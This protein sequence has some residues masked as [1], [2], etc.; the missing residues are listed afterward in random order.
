MDPVQRIEALYQAGKITAEEAQMLRE[1]VEG[2]PEAAQP[3]ASPSA[4]VQPDPPVAP[5]A[6]EAAQVPV[7]LLRLE[8]KAGDVTVEGDPQLTELQVM[9]QA[10]VVREGEV[11]RVSPRIPMRQGVGWVTQMLGQVAVGDLRLRIPAHWGVEVRGLAGDLKVRQVAWVKGHWAAGDVAL[12]E[13]KGVD[14][15]MRA[16]DLEANLH[17]TQGQHRL[18]LNFGDLEVKL[19]PGSDVTVTGQVALGDLESRTFDLDGRK[20]QGSL[21][22][23][24]ARLELSVTAGDLSVDAW[25]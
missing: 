14:F 6:P 18:S 24:Q 25:K 11:V 9:G 7:R 21:G 1:A 8:V 2:S 12:Q 15:T 19:L 5:L 13:V 3:V 10:D 23:G 4:P 16:G 22:A 20:L 17:L